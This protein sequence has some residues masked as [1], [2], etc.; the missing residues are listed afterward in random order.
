MPG[1]AQA[2]RMDF[3]VRPVL[4]GALLSTLVHAAVACTSVG[5]QRMIM[6]LWKVQHE[7]PDIHGIKR[8]QFINGHCIPDASESEFMV[9]GKVLA[10]IV[11]ASKW[12]DGVCVEAREYQ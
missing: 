1:H 3:T 5:V 10:R 7:V 2:W 12:D 6:Y 4:R 8:V 9:C 11:E